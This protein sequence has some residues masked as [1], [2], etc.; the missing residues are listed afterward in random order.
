[1]G[2]KMHSCL[3]NGLR[4]YAMHQASVASLRSAWS[5]FAVM[6]MTGHFDPDAASRR[7]SSIHEIPP[8]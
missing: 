4:K 6:Q 2:T 8:R 5:S 1:M 7:C 3:P